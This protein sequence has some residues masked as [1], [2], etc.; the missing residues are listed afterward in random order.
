MS[1]FALASVADHSN[2][3]RAPFLRVATSGQ[4]GLAVGFPHNRLA[5]PEL[6]APPAIRHT[7]IVTPRREPLYLRIK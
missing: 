1:V 5:Q 4:P 6:A 3:I 2:S 7:P